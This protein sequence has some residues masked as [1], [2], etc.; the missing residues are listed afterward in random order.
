MDPK[1]SIEAILE[2]G[3]HAFTL[4][5]W[6]LL[7]KIDSPLAVKGGKGSILE[8]LFVMYAPSETLRRIGYRCEE[9]GIA[10]MEWAD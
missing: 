8:T 6:A 1:A 9:I 7:E 2:K 3:P 10:A 4:A 5:R